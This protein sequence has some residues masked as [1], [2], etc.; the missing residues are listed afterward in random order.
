ML[1]G[2]SIRQSTLRLVQQSNNIVNHDLCST[3]SRLP[4]VIAL[5]SEQVTGDSPYLQRVAA[6]QTC[7]RA[8]TGRFRWFTVRNCHRWRHC[9]GLSLCASWTAVYGGG[10]NWNGSL[11]I[12][13]RHDATVGKLTSLETAV[14]KQ[15]VS[16]YVACNLKVETEEVTWVSK[17]CNQYTQNLLQTCYSFSIATLN[18]ACKNSI[19]LTGYSLS[20]ADDAARDKCLLTRRR[21]VTLLKLI[22]R[23]KSSNNVLTW[24][25]HH[26]HYVPQ[27]CY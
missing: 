23:I 22:T 5:L 8:A 7:A 18:V 27:R 4:R 19:S 9:C 2:N 24:Q 10:V 20:Q 12:T 1:G 15:Y 26:G 13:I 3:R 25:L 16:K 6:S 11:R 21:H 14:K 17:T